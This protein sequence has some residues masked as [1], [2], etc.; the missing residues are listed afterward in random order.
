MEDARTYWLDAMLRIASPVLEALSR[1]ALAKEMPV[2][3]HPDALDRPQ[4][5]YL[6]ALGRTLMGLAPWLEHRAEDEREEARRLRYAGMARKAIRMAVDPASPDCMNF[7]TGQQP[8]V[9]AAFLAQALLRAPRELYENLEDETKWMLLL[10]MKSTRTRRPAPNNWLLFSAI[11]EVFLYAAGEKDWDPMRIDYALRQHQQWYKGDG[12][13]GDGAQLHADYYN[14]FVIQPMIADILRRMEGVDPDWDGMKE[15][16][17]RRAARLASL[18]EQLIACDGT[19]P[20]LGRS[21]CYRFGAFHALAQAALCGSLEEGVTPAQVR[22][23][24]TAVIQRVLAYPTMFDEK[25]WLHIGVCGRQ[26]GMGEPY[27]STG[28]LYLC[29]AVFL[30]LGLPSSAPFWSDPDENWTARKIWGGED[31]RGGHPLQE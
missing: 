7:E 23:A 30:P 1:G 8:I 25:G 29:M 17:R 9:D 28:S 24:L 16:A 22:C 12:L 21:S 3:H 20:V 27:I 4:Y 2:R 13:Y 11:I 5:T 10:K 14:S 19:Y 31:T 18:L 15:T 6:E 26:P